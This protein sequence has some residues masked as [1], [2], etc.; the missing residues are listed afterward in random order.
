MRYLTIEEIILIHEYELQKYGGHPGIR[1]IAL[2]ESSTYRPQTSF[3]ERELYKTP[4]EKAA[5]L[6][7][8]IIKNHPF[9]DGNKRT[10][11][12]SSIIFLKLNGHNLKLSQKKLVKIALDTA[13]GILSLDKITKLLGKK[14]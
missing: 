7:Y 8:V 12:V 13:K 3:G 9:V 10:A 1:N 2:L 11:V 4:F 5:C 14:T 6:M